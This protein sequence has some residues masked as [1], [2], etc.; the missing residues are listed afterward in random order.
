MPRGVFVGTS[1]TG[2][3]VAE[4]HYTGA[5]LPK[6]GSDGDPMSFM[7]FRIHSKARWVRFIS[8]NAAVE[9]E[10]DSCVRPGLLSSLVS[11]LGQGVVEFTLVFLL[12]L[13]IAW[14]PADFG[15][16]FYTGQLALNASRE[17]ARI[18][19]V[20]PTLATGTTTCTL[21]ACYSLTNGT[22]LKETAK[23][24]SSALIP[25]AQI[26]VTYPVPGGV[27]CNRQLVVNVTGNYNF[28]FYRLLRLLGADVPSSVQITRSTT[29]RWEHQKT[30]T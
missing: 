16:A 26:S 13:I 20:D 27:L 8:R 18:A 2:P 25:G 4:S 21:P 14:I 6:I 29:M 12:F 24:I 19:A 10:V 30:C 1:Y 11:N 9:A 15:L 5:K 23:R 3:E 22:I 28:F 7:I 17:G